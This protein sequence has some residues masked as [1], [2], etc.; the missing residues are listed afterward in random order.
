MNFLNHA[1]KAY[2]LMAFFPQWVKRLA[3]ECIFTMW[4]K[5]TGMHFS[6]MQFHLLWENN[7]NK[8]LLSGPYSWNTSIKYFLCNHWYSYSHINC[9]FEFNATWVYMRI[10]L[11]MIYLDIYCLCFMIETRYEYTFTVN[12]KTGKG[13]KKCNVWA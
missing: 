9:C 10:V 4:I 8:K 11:L 2:V 12:W 1:L 13:E 7:N 5:F 6:G 3:T